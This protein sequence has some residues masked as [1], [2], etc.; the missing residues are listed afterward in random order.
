MAALSETEDWEARSFGDIFA[1]DTDDLIDDGLASRDVAASI[2]NLRMR[3]NDADYRRVF[4]KRNR[5]IGEDN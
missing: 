2:F 5:F 1:D 4:D 3:L